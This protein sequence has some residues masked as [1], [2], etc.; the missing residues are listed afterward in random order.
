MVGVSCVCFSVVIVVGWLVLLWFA[1]VDLDVKVVCLCLT[2][3]FQN[4]QYIK[5]SN[6]GVNVVLHSFFQLNGLVSKFCGDC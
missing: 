2:M 4:I 1:L 3:C 5:Y 6:F